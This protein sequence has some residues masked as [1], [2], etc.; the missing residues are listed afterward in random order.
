MPQEGAQAAKS[1]HST[2]HDTCVLSRGL[3][4]SVKRFLVD[5]LGQPTDLDLSILQK[6]I[7]LGNI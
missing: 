7:V 2:A 1:V 5:H 3:A 6:N 4:I